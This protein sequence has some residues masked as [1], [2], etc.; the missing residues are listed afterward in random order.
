MTDRRKELLN[1]IGFIWNLQDA[2]WEEKLNKHVKY[3]DGIL[4]GW[5]NNQQKNLGKKHRMTQ[6]S[7]TEKINQRIKKLNMLVTSP[8]Y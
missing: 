6:K 3:K 1:S 5:A 2:A 4:G 7:N 8:S